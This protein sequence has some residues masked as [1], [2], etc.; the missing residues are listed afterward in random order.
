[1]ERWEAGDCRGEK[2]D[3]FERYVAVFMQPGPGA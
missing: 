2:P 3:E 1:M